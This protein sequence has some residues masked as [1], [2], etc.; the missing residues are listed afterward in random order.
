MQNWLKANG[1]IEKTEFYK[2]SRFEAAGL[3]RLERHAGKI[4]TQPG[5]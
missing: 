2:L 1:F 4:Q 5:A 3:S